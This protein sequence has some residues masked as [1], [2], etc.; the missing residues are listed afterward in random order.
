MK[1]TNYF[2]ALEKAEDVR[3]GLEGICNHYPIGGVVEESDERLDDDD[4]YNNIGDVD[5]D[6]V[7]SEWGRLSTIKSVTST[8]VSDQQ[9]DE[10]KKTEPSPLFDRL[11]SLLVE[12]D[13]G[14]D[15][16]DDDDDDH[17]IA[18]LPSFSP[19]EFIHGPSDGT[20]KSSNFQLNQNDDNNAKKVDVSALTLDQR[21]YIQLR[22]AGLL[23]KTMPDDIRLPTTPSSS[24]SKPTLTIIEADED[25][26]PLISNVL[27]KM[28]MDLST[29]NVQTYAQAAELQ[30]R[31]LSDVAS[32]ASLSAP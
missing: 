21:T 29:L 15:S 12:V 23:G 30:R 17:L 32:S 9:K 19:E 27:Q 1:H 31:A 20:N 16:D 11:Q 24:S 7:S 28:K 3:V 14:S 10:E 26:S 8:N 25:N 2:D 18:N 6:D 13:E 22:A 5:D 4:E